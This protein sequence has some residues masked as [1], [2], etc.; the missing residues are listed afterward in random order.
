MNKTSRVAN[1]NKPDNPRKYNIRRTYIE[2]RDGKI[3]G[4]GRESDDDIYSRLRK[5]GISKEHHMFYERLEIYGRLCGKKR[6]VITVKEESESVEM[7][8]KQ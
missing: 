5:N 3:R 1:W 8:R 4:A 2:A 7:W 6:T